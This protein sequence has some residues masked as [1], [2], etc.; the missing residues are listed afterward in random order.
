MQ[1]Q[2]K[3]DEFKQFFESRKHQNTSKGGS[4]AKDKEKEKP[5][6]SVM[7]QQQDR[8]EAAAKRMQEL[9]RNFATILRQANIFTLKIIYIIY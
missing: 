6:T 4:A 2:Q 3:A 9:M 1:I 5:I 7:K 8:E